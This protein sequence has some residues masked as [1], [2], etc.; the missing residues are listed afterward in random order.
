MSNV[1]VIRFLAC[2]LI[3]IL[4]NLRIVCACYTADFT[5]LVLV[6]KFLKARAGTS[7]GIICLDVRI[8][9]NL[10]HDFLLFLVII[11]VFKQRLISVHILH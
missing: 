1:R 10:I 6:E 11:L 8:L 5:L 9:Q 4:S 7:L 3:G 2:P